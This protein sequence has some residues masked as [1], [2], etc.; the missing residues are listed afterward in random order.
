[1]AVPAISFVIIMVL[2]KKTVGKDRV[3]FIG[4]A[5][6]GL[7]WAMSLVAAFQWTQRIEDPPEGWQSHPERLGYMLF[8]PK[9]ESSGPSQIAALRRAL[10]RGQRPS[11]VR[12]KVLSEGRGAVVMLNALR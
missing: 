3:H 6:V 4:I 11:P 10:P 1:M 7:V 9:A 8:L 12:L 5:A 2:G